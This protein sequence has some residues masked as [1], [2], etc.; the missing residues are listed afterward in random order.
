MLSSTPITR[1]VTDADG[2]LLLVSITAEWSG[3]PRESVYLS[4][5]GGELVQSGTF[6]TRYTRSENARAAVTNGFA[7]T[8]LRDT[9]WP[10]A[11]IKVRTTA[12]D[13]AGNVTFDETSY[14]VALPAPGVS[15]AA[16]AGE[17]VITRAL[18]VDPTTGDVVHNGRNLELV[19]GLE[20]VAQSL[21]TRLAFFQGEWFLNES[22]GT[23]WFQTILGKTIPILAVREV[24]RTIITDTVGVRSVISL[25]LEQIT[26]SPRDF[27]LLFTVDTDLNEFLTLTVAVGV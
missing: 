21:R 16:A 25:E 22:F 13:S 24:L 19:S 11:S 26:G 20:A 23:P 17:V 15:S 2:D 14:A 10:A 27:Q 12:V 8:F 3:A 6:G 1:T 5:V 18:R 9:L 4:G 7:Y